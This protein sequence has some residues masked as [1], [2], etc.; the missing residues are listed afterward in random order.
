[1]HFKLNRKQKKNGSKLLDLLQAIEPDAKHYR[2]WHAAAREYGDEAARFSKLY[3]ESTKRYLGD[4]LKPLEKALLKH[5]VA[6]LRHLTGANRYTAALES[7]EI[8]DEIYKLDKAA[9][10]AA[11]TCVTQMNNELHPERLK[12]IRNGWREL[13]W[14][15]AL[16]VLPTAAAAAPLFFSWWFAPVSWFI[17][18]NGRVTI[19]HWATTSLAEHYRTQRRQTRDHYNNTQTLRVA[20]G[21]SPADVRYISPALI[22]RIVRRYAAEKQA[23]LAA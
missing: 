11:A 15:A 8:H 23:K 22:V 5:D 12:P 18:Y 3:G 17:F 21:F 14:D 7:R 20:L 19:K 2:A 6:S 16:Q 4:E 9:M 1:M 13:A 10:N